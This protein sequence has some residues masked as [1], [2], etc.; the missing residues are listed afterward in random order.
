MT[1][2]T[3]ELLRKL[4]QFWQAITYFE[5]SQSRKNQNKSQRTYIPTNK[6]MYVH[7]FLYV[8]NYI[9]VRWK[10]AKS[11][12]VYLE[13]QQNLQQRFSALYYKL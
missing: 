7:A 10:G 8:S 11:L 12:Q 2:K 6:H 3:V 9:G 4:H 13:H 5:R 1:T